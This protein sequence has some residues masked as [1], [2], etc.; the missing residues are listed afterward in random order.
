[1]WSI[2]CI[3]DNYSM[4][5]YECEGFTEDEVKEYLLEKNC[6]VEDDYELYFTEE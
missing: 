5:L 2:R 3:G 4:V 6:L 1:M